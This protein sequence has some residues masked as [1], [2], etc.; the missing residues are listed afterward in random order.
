METYIIIKCRL[1]IIGKDFSARLK[2]VLPLLISS[3]Q[4]AYV[5]NRFVGESGRLIS[6]FFVNEK[7]K[8]KSYLVTIDIEEVFGSF[9]HSFLLIK[10]EKFCFGTNFIDWIK[11]FSNDQELCVINGGVTPQYFKLEKGAQQGD[12]VY[13]G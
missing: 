13:P 11:I 4:T 5:S 12:P 8:T 3:Q 6:D 7:F 2:K 1:K 9:D 10:L